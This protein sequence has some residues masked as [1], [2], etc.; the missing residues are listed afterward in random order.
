[1]RCFTN[2]FDAM[3]LK[4]TYTHI[5]FVSNEIYIWGGSSCVVQSLLSP[6]SRED[7]VEMR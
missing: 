4:K 5:F 7:M 6:S 3:T 2:S 1:M